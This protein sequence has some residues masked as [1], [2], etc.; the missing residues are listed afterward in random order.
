MISRN[1]LW[2]NNSVNKIENILRIVQP[3]YIAETD[4]Y[5]NLLTFPQKTGQGEK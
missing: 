2:Y 3:F 5:A 1:K 4:I